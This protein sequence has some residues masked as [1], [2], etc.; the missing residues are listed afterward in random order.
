MLQGKV[1]FYNEER[2]FGFLARDDG[3]EDVFVHVR[4]VADGQELEKGNVVQF[5]I[6]ED[7]RSG[8]T[9]AVNVRVVE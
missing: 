6:G 2:G 9:R 8:R 7:G 3:G 5:D 4:E 1:K